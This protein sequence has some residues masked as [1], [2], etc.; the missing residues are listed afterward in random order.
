[1]V[2]MKHTRTK[3][4][5]KKKKKQKKNKALVE[6]IVFLIICIVLSIAFLHYKPDDEPIST[7]RNPIPRFN[8]PV[9][10]QIIKHTGFTVS[11]C[12]KHRLPHW[13]SYELTR[14]K[15]KGEY[16]RTNKFVRD[17]HVKGTSA[18][19]S[20]YTHSGYDRGHMAPAADMRWS[21][22]AMT[23]SFF[24]SNICPQHPEL[25]RQSWKTLEDKVRNWAVADS[26]IIIVCGPIVKERCKK[27]GDNKVSIPDGFFKVILSPFTNPPQAIGFLFKNKES[28]LPVKE[29]AV[30]VDSV[31]VVTGLDFF[32]HLPD[33]VE[34]IVEASINWKHWRLR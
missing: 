8:S 30:T 1:M 33:N 11:Y 24:L 29:Y 15:V 18:H 31:E 34:S 2:T 3:K 26:A 4:R 9:A 7:C 13:V 25:N 20:D 21:M 6:V 28:V 14:D 32:H 5:K 23:E 12:E 19:T 17:P 27:I 16:P 10:E 22:D